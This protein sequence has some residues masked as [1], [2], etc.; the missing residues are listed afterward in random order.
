MGGEANKAITRR[1]SDEIW[2]GKDLTQ[3][4][5]LVSENYTVH[6]GGG[7]FSGRDAMRAVAEQWHLPFPDLRVTVLQ[8]VAE[9]DRVVDY[10]LFE[11]HHT[12]TAFWPG[13]FR[14]LGLP[15][16]PATGKEFKFTQTCITRIEDG[17]MV[18][19]WEDFDRIRLWLQLGVKLVVPE[20]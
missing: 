7:S 10:L 5:D 17:R 3:L 12:G 2:T 6:V 19:T 16:I 18:E 4:E 9:G 8:Q 13:L 11:G 1:F 14:A 20:Q 15:A